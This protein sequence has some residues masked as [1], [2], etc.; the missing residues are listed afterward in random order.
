MNDVIRK[1]VLHPTS[2]PVIEFSGQ[3]IIQ[4]EGNDSDGQTGG[5]WHDIGVYQSDDGELFVEIAYQTSA[6]GELPDCQVEQ[7]SDASEVDAT[8]SLYEPQQFIRM[9]PGATRNRLVEQLLHR[10]DMQVNE[11]LA[12]LPASQPTT[13]TSKPR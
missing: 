2:K 8:L 11:V 6:T 4:L 13:P 9:E 3:P 7:A 5:R 1:I 10:Y 12:A